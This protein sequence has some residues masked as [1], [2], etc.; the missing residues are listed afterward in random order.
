MVRYPALN[1]MASFID[2]PDAVY[3]T[4]NDASVTMDGSSIV[5]GVTPSS[6]VYTMA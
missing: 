4:G 2:S 3:G 1:A 5:V 6:N